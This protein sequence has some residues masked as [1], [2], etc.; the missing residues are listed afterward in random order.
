M[1]DFFPYYKEILKRKENLNNP[2][3][4]KVKSSTFLRSSVMHTNTCKY[5]PTHLTFFKHK[6]NP[7][8]GSRC[9]PVLLLYFLLTY[10]L[11]LLFFNK[12]YPTIF[13]LK[14]W[15]GHS[16]GHPLEFLW[17]VTK[18]HFRAGTWYQEPREPHCSLNMAQIIKITNSTL[19]E[20]SSSK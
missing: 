16:H 17:Y 9:T 4:F 11:L 20:S 12:H 19:K 1:L 15:E 18:C 14:S 2:C 6:K 3:P 7:Q 8:K 13:L 10:L 5:R